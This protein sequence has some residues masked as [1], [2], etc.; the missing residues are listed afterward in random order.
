MS[1]AFLKKNAKKRDFLRKISEK[2]TALLFPHRNF[3]IFHL[4]FFFRGARIK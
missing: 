4:T 2:P 1:S 3:A